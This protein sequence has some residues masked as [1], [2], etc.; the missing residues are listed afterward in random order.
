MRVANASGVSLTHLEVEMKPLVGLGCIAQRNGLGYHLD[1]R[2][3]WKQYF[4]HTGMSNEPFT[5][6]YT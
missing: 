4:Y 1:R 2:S 3:N 6:V 5:M